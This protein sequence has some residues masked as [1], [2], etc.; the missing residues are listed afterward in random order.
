MPEKILDGVGMAARIAAWHGTN[1]VMNPPIPLDHARIAIGTY[2]GGGGE[3]VYAIAD[4]WTLG[5]VYRGALN[6]SFGAYASR[7]GL[8]YLVDERDDG[9][10]GVHRHTRTG[11]ECLARVSVAG[12]APCH[13][14][15]DHAQTRLAVA[16]YAS[17]SMSLVRL[18]DAGLP[19]GPPSTHANCGHGPNAERQEG[20]H[21]HWVGFSP[22]DRWLYQT[23]LGTDQILAY[24]VGDD[25]LGTPIVAYAAPAGSGPRHLLLHPHDPTRA[26][27]ISEMASTLT[28][29]DRSEGRFQARAT[30]STLPNDWHGETIVAHIAMNHAGD[31]LYVSNRGHDSIAVFALDADGLPS[32]LQHTPAGGAYPRFF[33]LMEDDGYMI[34]ANEKSQTVTV[35]TL[36]DDGR[37]EP[38][39]INLPVPGA[40]YIIDLDPTP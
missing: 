33:R 3:G 37:L 36:T 22:D 6:A 18:D 13:V 23:D 11:W 19:V 20:P 24:P 32:L 14:A 31:R 2:A 39:G 9:A 7:F 30:I 25:G 8:H 26:Y 17:G 10:I 38:T 5:D 28:V 40:A 35:L 27:L 1:T 16:N 15:L 21:A 4:R 12:D 29:L 34:V